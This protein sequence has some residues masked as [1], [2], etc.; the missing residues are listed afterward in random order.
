MPLTTSVPARPLFGVGLMLVAMA[1]LPFID[2]LAKF[3]GQ[4]G[5]PILIVVWARALFGA[6]MTLPF[7]LQAQGA[8]AFRPDWP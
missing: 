8:R 1:I 6:T 3:L 5:L 4:Q 2:V 7:A